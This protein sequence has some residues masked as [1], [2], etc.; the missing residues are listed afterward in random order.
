MSGV[1]GVLDLNHFKIINDRYGHEAGDSILQKAGEV[2]SHH[3]AGREIGV[4]VGASVGFVPYQ[5]YCDDFQSLYNAADHK[6]YEKKQHPLPSEQNRAFD[7]SRKLC[8][9]MQADVPLIE[10]CFLPC[11]F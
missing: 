6:M 2:L 3:T 5:K 8:F 4:P 10:I 11:I 1:F 7:D 9:F